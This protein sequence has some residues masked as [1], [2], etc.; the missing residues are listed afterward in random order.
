MAIPNLDQA[1]QIYADALQ[2]LDRSDP[3]LSQLSSPHPSPLP[4]QTQTISEPSQQ[5]PDEGI[6]SVLVARDRVQSAY[7]AH[8]KTSNEPPPNAT[9]LT[10]LSQLDQRLRERAGTM[11]ASPQLADWRSSFALDATTWWWS[12]FDPKSEPADR[13]QWLW[14]AGTVTS[15]TVSLGLVGDIVPRFL[16]GTPDSLGAVSVSVQSILT[17]LVA[18]GTLTKAGQLALQQFLKI[19]NCP[20]KNWPA[21]GTG[22]ALVLMLGLF[23]LR[24]SLPQIATAWYTKPGIQN[25]NRGDWGTAE[26][27][28]KR[29]LKLNADDFQ[30]HFQLGKLYEELQLTSQ[31]RT[32][33]LLAMQGGIPPA[34]NNL[35]RLNI[36]EGKYPAAVSLLQKALL[37][38]QTP[39]LTPE[40]EHAVL[41]NLG[42]ARLKQKHYI[43]AEDSLNEAVSL[44]S[45]TQFPPEAIAD[46]HCLLAQVTEAQGDK[47][48]ALPFWNTCNKNANPTIPEHDEWVVIARERLESIEVKP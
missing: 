18:G 31:A 41:K 6:L 10:H 4:S 16:T 39:S 47:Q 7:I 28:F 29:S 43:D 35:A 45:E 19:L 40:A 48:A 14:Q 12:L 1:I 25:F 5:P 3:Q 26:A 8:I 9:T 32:H 15:L 23:G 34:T 11:V 37:S 20:E 42:W 36:L 22:S 2:T 17:L 13:L 27:Q 38:E 46:T 24:H 21:V 44:E 30:A 33:Y